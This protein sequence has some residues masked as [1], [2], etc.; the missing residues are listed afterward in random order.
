MINK[1][2]QHTEAA[3]VWLSKPPADWGQLMDHI[4]MA[5]QEL[6]EVVALADAMGKQEVVKK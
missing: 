5:R 3:Y 6:R 1:L 4:A 2:K